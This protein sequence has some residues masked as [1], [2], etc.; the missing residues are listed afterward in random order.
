MFKN[1]N[2]SNFKC[3][4]KESMEFKNITI[5]TGANAVG[6]SS[7][8]QSLLLL[9][10][11]SKKNSNEILDVNKIL[12]IQ[13]GSPKTLVAQN[14]VG[15]AEYDFQ[16]SADGK[17]VDYFIDKE[18]G[19]DLYCEKDKKF[20]FPELQY[21]NAERMGPRMFYSAGGEK[22]IRQDGSNATYLVECADNSGLV[23]STELM[24]S[25]ISGKFSYQV[26]CW[27][28]T[29]LG[30]LQLQIQ[31]DNVKAQSELRIKNGMTNEAIIPTLTGFGISY[32]FPIVVAGL[33]ATTNHNQVLIVE[34]PEAHLHPSAQSAIGK[35]LA[36]IA[37]S[38]TQVIV[39][40]HSEHV[41]DG[42]RMQMTCMESTE[43]MLVNYMSQEYGNM[44]I[45]KINIDKKGELDEWPE[46]FFDQKQTDLRQL[47]QMRMKNGNNQ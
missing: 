21:V 17:Y 43:D 7:I 16:L 8:I 45:L 35:F 44:N 15:N 29:I 32:V 41:I 26:E 19:L 6:K 28:S 33:L 36:I 12:G 2:I 5:L 47:F 13:I 24:L 38:G 42:A 1:I 34:N 25:D 10:G 31:V 30:E 22:K 20:E 37:A 46:G 14:A 11:A 3:L 23:I 27:M 40:T 9:E 18:N 39:E 4:V